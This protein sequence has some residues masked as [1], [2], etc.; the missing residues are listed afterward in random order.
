MKKSKIKRKLSWDNKGALEGLP[1]Y[2]IILVVIAAISI[3][4]IISWLGSIST[5]KTFGTITPSPSQITLTDDDGDDISSTE[6]GSLTVTVRDSDDN[7]IKGATVTLSGC[8]A[9]FSSGGTA[10]AETNENG[11]AVF[12]GL[13]LEVTKG[14]TSSITVKAQKSDYPDKEITVPVIG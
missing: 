14:S 3:V 2:L 6:T 4:V 11:E 5:P 10:W 8:D 7:R 1:L 13:H 12:T 9:R